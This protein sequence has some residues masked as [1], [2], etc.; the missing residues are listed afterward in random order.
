MSLS[1]LDLVSSSDLSLPAHLVRLPSL[2]RLSSPLYCFQTVIFSPCLPSGSFLGGEPKTDLFTEI[3][4][5]QQSEVIH[6]TSSDL[7]CGLGL[8]VSAGHRVWL[9][10][11]ER[12]YEER[13]K[14]E[15][16]SAKEEPAIRVSSFSADCV[17]NSTSSERFFPLTWRQAA[18]TQQEYWKLLLPPSVGLQKSYRVDK[19]WGKS[20]FLI[21][22]TSWVAGLMAGCRCPV[23]D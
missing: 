1:S 9:K 23:P 6:R 3:L 11:P 14:T 13:K 4:I 15:N 22:V 12:N 5:K 7:F 8:D 16:L 19:G 17:I 21:H 20:G 2:T 18:A 10:G